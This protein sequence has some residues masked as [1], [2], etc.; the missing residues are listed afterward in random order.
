MNERIYDKPQIVL[1]DA[2]SNY[3]CG[4][5]TAGTNFKCNTG[6]AFDSG[7]T[8]STTGQWANVACSAGTNVGGNRCS[9]GGGASTKCNDGTSAVGTCKTG[10]GVI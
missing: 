8:C 7:A 2:G 5:C 10:T 6:G 9:L 1:L 3:G 4:S